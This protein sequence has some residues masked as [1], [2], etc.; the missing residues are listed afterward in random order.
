VSADPIPVHLLTG[1]LGSGKTTLLSRLVRQE[2]FADTAVVI[3]E[4]GEVGIDNVLVDRSTEDGVVLLDSGCLCCALG[5]SLQETLEDLYFRRVRGEIPP[6]A[7]LVIETTGIAD[8][9]PIAA[10]LALDSA[11]ARHYRLA[12]IVTT[13]DAVH[14]GEELDRF[15]EALRQVALA[16][17]II[18][19]K[20]DIADEARTRHLRARIVS[21]NPHAAQMTAVEGV[22]A[23]GDVLREAALPMA[24]RGGATAGVAHMHGDDH[25][26]G[27]PHDHVA[28]Q[29]IASRIVRL[30]APLPWSRYAEWVAWMQRTFG[31]K[32]LRMKGVVRMDDGAAYALHAVMRLFNA[33]RPLA[34]LP[35]DAGAGVI[36]VIAQHAEST[37]FDD[38]MRRLRHG[39]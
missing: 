18:V 30:D 20:T 31:E 6:F 27:H 36:V 5:N 37:L 14:G 24:T 11:I 7:R 39:T 33:P 22:A 19:T 32:L 23:A 10:T 28:E 25:D 34:S 15:G 1:F 35:E 12:G 3:N 17:R 26:H 2:G 16:D 9:G 13:V 38:A 29:G 4:L 21:L 8:P